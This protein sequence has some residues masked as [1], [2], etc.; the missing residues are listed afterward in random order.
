MEIKKANKNKPKAQDNPFSK[1]SPAF[2]VMEKE[3][4]KR[5]P[6]EVL[7]DIRK[8]AWAKP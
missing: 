5:D 6:R 7:K 2:G 8:R 4:N 1:A 3:W